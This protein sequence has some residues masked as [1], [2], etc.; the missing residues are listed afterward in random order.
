MIIF[1][2]HNFDSPIYQEGPE[3]SCLMIL[4]YKSNLSTNGAHYD[5][6][7][8]KI[9]DNER[10]DLNKETPISA[11][12]NVLDKTTEEIHPSRFSFLNAFEEFNLNTNYPHS[13]N[14]KNMFNE[15]FEYLVNK[16]FQK[17][18]PY[19]ERFYDKKIPYNDRCNA[20]ENFR[21]SANENYKLNEN[22]QLFIR[23]RG[24]WK[25][26]PYSDNIP[27][28]ICKFHSDSLH[29]GI[30]PTADLIISRGF[31][32]FGIYDD[33]RQI[34]KN[35]QLCVENNPNCPPKS[36]KPIITSNPRERYQIDLT[37]LSNEQIEHYKTNQKY[38]FTMEDHFSKFGFACTQKTKEAE[39]TY[40]NF[41]KFIEEY[42]IPNIIHT[43]NGKD[44]RML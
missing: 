1:R 5:I 38:I 39:E 8:P 16:K 32:W 19:P 20:K 11:T 9:S 23:F 41:L 14:E 26:V 36:I 27:N 28:F 15:V 44:S 17:A 4:H 29:I 34:L 22:N 12:D 33:V 25:I 24:Q 10:Y 13:K 6:F 31:Y 40:E 18:F 35:C 43:D 37:E 2:D 3:T 30:N 7:G 21:K 42:G